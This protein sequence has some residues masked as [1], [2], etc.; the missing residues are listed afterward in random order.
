MRYLAFFIILF[1]LPGAGSAQGSGHQLRVMSFNILHG[2][3]SSGTMTLEKQAD[4]IKAAKPDLV[5][6]QEVDD[7][8]DRSRRVDQAKRLGELTGMHYA[9]GAHY[10]YQGGHYGNAILSRFPLSD[11]RDYRI[12]LF[13]KDGTTETRNL[14]SATATLDDGSTVVIASVHMGLNQESRL[15][16][17]EEIVDYLD[18]SGV[19]TILTGDLNAE[20]GTPELARLQKLFAATGTSVTGTY[21]VG[22]PAKTIDFIMVSR[23]DLRSVESYKV[24]NDVT[25]SD[26]YPIMAEFTV[27]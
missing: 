22:A 3:N 20:P 13:S 11:V 7:K 19:P 26:H 15:V 14:I 23:Q 10:E 5:G 18:D 6:L 1:A 24:L 25:Y 4:A 27:R 16:Q 2:T 12:S 17:A 9:F 21:P 8:V